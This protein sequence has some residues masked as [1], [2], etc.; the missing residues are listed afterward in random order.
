MKRPVFR[1]STVLLLVTFL[2]GCEGA[3]SLPVAPDR[4]S[5][6]ADQVPI[7]S[8]KP[9]CPGHPS[10]GEEDPAGSDAINLSGHYDTAEPQP[11]EVKSKGKILDVKAPSENPIALFLELPSSSEFDFANTCNHGGL[12]STENAQLFWDTHA[13]AG[14]GGRSYRAHVDKKNV[15]SPDTEHFNEIFWAGDDSGVIK[16]RVGNHDAYG[17]ATWSLTGEDTYTITGGGLSIL[18]LSG[19][20]HSVEKAV[21]CDNGAN[22]NG[23]VQVSL[24]FQLTTLP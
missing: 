6:A 10:C 11:V 9:S 1:V 21:S 24:T 22:T 18:K 13:G 7:A 17:P 15:G 16:V 19:P 3:D 4:G 14:G 23:G 2:L 5:T 8:A 20:D 12:S